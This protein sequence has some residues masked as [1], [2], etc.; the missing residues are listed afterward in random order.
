MSTR[1]FRDSERAK[2]RGTLIWRPKADTRTHTW[3]GEGESVGEN[4][5]NGL[6]HICGYKDSL[7]VFMS[8][9]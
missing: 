7:L 5:G 1:A 2:T 3:G 8:H 4:E 6:T 9:P